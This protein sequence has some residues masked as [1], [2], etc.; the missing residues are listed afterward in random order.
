MGDRAVTRRTSLAIAAGL[1]LDDWQRLG[2][3]IHTIAESSTWWLGDWLVYGQT[4]YPDRY[5][6]VIARTALDY[7][8]LRNYA[9]VVRRFPPAARHAGLSF[10]HHAE[11]AGLPEDEREIWLARAE[12]HGW[13]RNEL[14]T[15]IRARCRDDAAEGVQQVRVN[16]VESQRQ[17]WSEAAGRCEQDLLSWMVSTLDSAAATALDAGAGAGADERHRLSSAG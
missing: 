2:D 16:L 3:Q 11:A 5:K 4:E 15:R 17:L 13:S 10:Q 6:Q 9:W 8:T 12:E 14:R 1:P 7:Q